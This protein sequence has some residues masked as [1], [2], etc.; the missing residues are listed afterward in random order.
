MAFV[1][2]AAADDKHRLYMK[3]KQMHKSPQLLT[4]NYETG[5]LAEA[6][7]LSLIRRNRMSLQPWSK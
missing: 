5:L 2:T 6:I 7:A 4:P 1:Q 3:L